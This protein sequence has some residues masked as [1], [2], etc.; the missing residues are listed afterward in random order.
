MG[1]DSQQTNRQ[2]NHRWHFSRRWRYAVRRA[3][4]IDLL[5]FWRQNRSEFRV[6]AA[7]GGVLSLTQLHCLRSRR[8]AHHYVTWFDRPAQRDWPSS[9]PFDPRRRSRTGKEERNGDRDTLAN[10]SLSVVCSLA[11][12]LAL[13]TQYLIRSC[14]RPGETD[15]DR[16]TGGVM[17]KRMRAVDGT[18]N[19]VDRGT[20]AWH[21][22]SHVILRGYARIRLRF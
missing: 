13:R 15:C 2:T 10:V 19:V 11:F 3:L 16:C 20:W 14:G 7:R 9:T 21:R 4:F 8:H 12:R 22:H 18:I 1:S 5:L 6:L 17:T